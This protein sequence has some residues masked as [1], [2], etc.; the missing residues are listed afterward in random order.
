MFIVT[1]KFSKKKAVTGIIIL[2]VVLTIIIILAGIGAKSQPTSA[3][4]LSATVK[5]NAQRVEYLQKLG[6]QVEV[7]A[8]DQQNITIP[9]QFNEIYEEY[10]SLQKKQGFDLKDYAGMDATRYTYQILNY[11][12]CED[13]VVADII[14]YKDKIIA[15]DVQSTALDGFMEGLEFPS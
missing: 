8:I 14:V 9:K 10:N 3:P 12:N 15:G 2:A 11:P 7:E 13:N 6:W 5:D 1:T 4:A